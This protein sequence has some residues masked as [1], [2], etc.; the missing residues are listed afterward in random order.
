MLDL[1]MGIMACNEAEN[2][3]R[4]LERIDLQTLTRGKLREIFVVASGCTD[5]TEDIVREHAARDSRIALLV[6]E[7]R[8]GKAS[9]INLFLSRAT[10]EVLL[11][12]S[13]D[14]LPEDGALD[15]LVAPF[16]DPEVGMTGARPVPVDPPDTFTGHCTHL[17]WALHH[18]IALE[19]PK[20]G[21]LVAFRNLV[22]EIPA[23]TAVDE[24][25]IEA[26]VIAAG[27][28]LQYVP[29]AVVRN[30]GPGTIGDLV[31]QRR[32]IAAGHRHLKS[33]GYR[34][35]TH[36]PLRILKVLAAHRQQ[37]RRI[38]WTCGAVLLEGWSRLLGAWDLLVLKRNPVIW[39]M[40]RTTKKL[41]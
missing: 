9:A 1:S 28:R 22:R 33:L 16:E 15:R 31:R 41:D 11:L 14:T 32:R 39:D 29:D 5:G 2:I 7:Q 35:S 13:G 38:G 30:K 21:E 40:A 34:V 36:S 3:G 4:L 6:Q 17:L 26:A 10:G 19:T 27:L 25:S 37:P 20:L 12:E 23:N 18:A 24:A 8:E